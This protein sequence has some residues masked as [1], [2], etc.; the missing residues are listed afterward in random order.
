ML[1]KTFQLRTAA[2]TPLDILFSNVVSGACRIPTRSTCTAKSVTDFDTT[3]S[4]RLRDEKQQ[5]VIPDYWLP[6]WTMEHK[7]IYVRIAGA[8]LAA[9]DPIGIRLWAN[10][11]RIQQMPWSG[12]SQGASL[13]AG[14]FWLPRGAQSLKGL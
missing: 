2:T 10:R 14:F 9:G 1:P 8:S 7:K 11:Q 3:G 12:T 13:L 4:G 6:Q 5:A